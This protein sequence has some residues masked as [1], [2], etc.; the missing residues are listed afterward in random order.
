MAL[1]ERFRQRLTLPAICAPMFLVSGP[2][3]VAAACKAG[4]VGALPR[5]NARSIE[6]FEEWLRDIRNDV[7]AYAEQNPGERMGPL[8]VNLATNLGAEELAAHLSL[9]DRYGVEIVISAVGNPT[10]LA[11]RVHD[12]GAVIFHDVTTMRFAEKA[13]EAGV[14]GLTCIGAGGGGH[15]GTISHLV[16]IPKIRSI[17][18]GTIVLAGAVSNGAAIRAAEILGADLS[19]LGTR[20]IATQESRASDEYKAMLLRGS[21]AGLMYTPDIAGVA[22]NWMVESMVAVGLDPGDL[23]KP[24]GG[25]MSHSHLPDGIRPWKNLWSAGQGIDL[26]DDIPSVAELVTRLRREYVAACETPDMAEVAR[27]VDDVLQA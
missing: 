12:F 27:L 4:L 22:A 24:A 20:F 15:S 6:M 3:L 26:I 25:K 18:D 23:P 13:I 19:Y 17:F 1:D 7:D 21:S 10:A 8:A 14:D 9:C 2:E 16:L 11:E 5:Q